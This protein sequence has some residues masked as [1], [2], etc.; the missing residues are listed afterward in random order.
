MEMDQQITDKL[1]ENIAV[2]Q[3]IHKVNH[4]IIDSEFQHDKAQRV[5][6]T[7]EEDKLLKQSVE[8]VGSDLPKLE[9]VL[10]SK[11][12]K[13]IYFRMLYQNRTG[14]NKREQFSE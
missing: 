5:R 14:E 9:S 7:T 6:W 3:A 13:Q 1:L 8:I 4:Q 10:V 11:N 12:K 2:V